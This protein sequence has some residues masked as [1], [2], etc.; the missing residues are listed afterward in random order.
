MILHSID[1]ALLSGIDIPERMNNPLD[2]QPHPLC[3]AV[4]KELQTY[5]SER[6]DWREEIDKGKMFGIL[7]VEN[8]KTEPGTPEIGYLAAYSGQIGGRSDWDDFVPAVFDYLQ[9]DGY[10]KT[11]EAE[12]SDI[13]QRIRQLEG[14]EH[15]KE[16]KIL[17]QQLQEE[18]KQTIAAYQEKMKEAKAKRDARRKTG[19]LTPEEEAEMVKESQFMKAELRRLKK[20]LSEK[21]TLETEYEA[22]QADIL[23]LKQLRKT[24]S[25]ALQQWLFSQFRMQN[26]E[27]KMKDLQ[28]IFR[29]AALRDYPQATLATSRIAALKMVPPAGSGEC[30]EPKLL[31]YAYLHGYKP[32]QM[33][34]FWWGE[35]PKE[36]IRHHL[37]FYPACNG[38]CKPILHWMLPDRVFDSKIA[39]KQA[40][41]ILYE[42]DQLAVIHK[43]SGLL[44]VP[45]RDSSQPSVYSIMRKKYPAASSPLI[46]HRLDMATSGLMIIAKT[47]FAYHRLQKEFLHHRVQK[48]YIAIIGCKDQEACDK[49]WEKTKKKEMKEEEERSSI[50]T[51]KQK[52]SLPLMPDYLDRPRQIVNHEQGK[53][54]ITEYEVLDRIDATHLRLALYPKTGRTHQLR[55][56]CAHHEGLNAPILGDPLYGNEKASRLHLHAEEITFEH[57]LTGKEINIKREADFIYP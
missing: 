4:C 8:A 36:E 55:V 46:V 56:H 24:L 21:T 30:C 42:D 3:I 43:P 32:L 33:A 38:K 11:H 16:A 57:P 28:E 40:L 18:R 20:S 12:I 48:K 51:E 22:Y 23:R 39:E 6:E 2:Y 49:I 29:D 5:L 17:I 45:G 19:N 54:A 52:I 1:Q 37:Q 34:M 9:P 35:S 15:L 13:N 25:D 50:A 27:G 31:Q 41:E 44:S 47:D 7:I 10:F 14:N 53:E 26:H